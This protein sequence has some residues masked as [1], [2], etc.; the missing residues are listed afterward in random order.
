MLQSLRSRTVSGI[1]SEGRVSVFETTGNH[2][3]LCFVEA[4]K[5]P[6]YRR[7]DSAEAV[8]RQQV[9][10]RIM[11]DYRHANSEK[12]PSRQPSVAQMWHSKSRKVINPLWGSCWKVTL[13]PATSRS[14]RISRISDTVSR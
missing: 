5:A 11:V 4:A 9:S 3:P 12:D 8:W 14:R 1:N 2:Y 6:N 10:V 7:C 13:R